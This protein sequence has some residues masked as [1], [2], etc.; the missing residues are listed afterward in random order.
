MSEPLRI[1]RSV[2]G[3]RSFMNNI[4]H[5]NLKVTVKMAYCLLRQVSYLKYID[6]IVA[7]VWFEFFRNLHNIV[8]CPVLPAAVPKVQY[9]CN[10]RIA[11]VLF[12]LCSVRCSVISYYSERHS[13]IVLSLVFYSKK[14]N[15]YIQVDLAAFRCQPVFCYITLLSV[16]PAVRLIR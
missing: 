13:G 12:Q 10:H 6:S 15:S 11:F 5:N 3:I 1:C 2:V 4:I 16:C 14:S 8:K 9:Y 7:H